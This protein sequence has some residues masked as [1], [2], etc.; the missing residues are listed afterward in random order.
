MQSINVKT[1]TLTD[2]NTKKIITDNPMIRTTK[3]EFETIGANSGWLELEDK[4]EQKQM[5][6]LVKL[7]KVRGQSFG[8]CAAYCGDNVQWTKMI[9][10]VPQNWSTTL[11]T[12]FEDQ[13][14]GNLEEDINTA[15]PMLMEI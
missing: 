6:G 10:D 4:Q 1:K 8:V 7:S 12:F 13:W 5:K 11:R 9:E 2:T 14:S 15:F 3:S